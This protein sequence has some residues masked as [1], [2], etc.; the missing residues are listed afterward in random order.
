MKILSL[1]KMLLMGAFF[2]P[3]T[4]ALALP[5]EI[6]EF[7]A[8]PGTFYLQDSS[9]VELLEYSRPRDIQICASRSMPPG[10]DD[11]KEPVALKLKYAGRERIVLPGNCFM[12]E[13]KQVSVTPAETLPDG[14][15]IEGSYSVR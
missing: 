9:D 12:F 3:S 15:M 5:D 4:S 8:P 1:P 10:T 6:A 13:A 2:V 14:I 7:Y 11:H